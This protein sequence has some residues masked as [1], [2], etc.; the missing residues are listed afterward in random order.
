MNT[1]YPE[2]PGRSR[3][4]I[5]TVNVPSWT[6]PQTA[7]DTHPQANTCTCPH[8]K[9]KLAA[10]EMCKHLRLAR[11][12]ADLSAATPGMLS[13]GTRV[14]VIDWLEHLYWSR[15]WGF[16][17]G[18]WQHTLAFDGTRWLVESIRLH[19]ATRPIVWEIPD[20]SGW[21]RLFPTHR[22]SFTKKG[23]HVA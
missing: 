16:D 17:A 3:V 23:K 2:D 22:N 19:N 7:Y 15:Y 21:E 8:K 1:V 5:G 13:D 14:L 6:D 9:R 10:Q 20:W 11:T 12:G 18:E 4:P